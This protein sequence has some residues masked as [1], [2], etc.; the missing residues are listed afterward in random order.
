MLPTL[1]TEHAMRRR[2]RTYFLL[3]GTVSSLALLAGAWPVPL[4]AFALLELSFSGV[5]ALAERRRGVSRRTALRRWRCEIDVARG[6][7]QPAP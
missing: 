2:E 6:I 5:D 1:Y 7:L 4:L 3:L